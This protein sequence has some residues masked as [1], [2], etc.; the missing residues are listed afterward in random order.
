MRRSESIPACVLLLAAAVGLS[1]CEERRDCADGQGRKMP[2][3]CCNGTA[4]TGDRFIYGGRGGTG[5]GDTVRGGSD[6]P[7][8]SREVRH[9]TE[10]NRVTCTREVA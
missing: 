8:V 2:D 1:G 10:C 5:Y 6:S 3:S 7:S 4:H 9:E